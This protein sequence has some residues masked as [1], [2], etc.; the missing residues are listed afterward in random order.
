MKKIVLILLI[1][2]IFAGTVIVCFKGFNVGLPYKSNINISV[3]VGKKI[4]DKDMQEITKEV[5]KG[6]QAIVQ[7]VELFEDMISITTEE[8]SEEELNEKKTELINKLNEKYEKEIEIVHNPKVKLSSLIKRYILPF[9]ISTIAIVIYQMIRF[10]KLGA[11]KT[12]LTTIIVLMLIGLTYASLIAI[13]RIPINKFIIPIG[14]AIYV[15]TIIVLNM[16][17]EKKLEENK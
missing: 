10:K 16:K 1:C 12:L 15:I 14:M 5:F 7:K 2:L 17:Y 8:M 11:T 6:K 3:Y 9:G 13:T 4:E